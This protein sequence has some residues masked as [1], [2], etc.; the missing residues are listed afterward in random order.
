MKYSWG[1]SSPTRYSELGLCHYHSLK[2][3]E[4]PWSEMSDSKSELSFSECPYSE[5]AL[6]F[7]RFTR[8]PVKT[9]R[10]SI[11]VSPG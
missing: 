6:P 4:N 5:Q 10:A 1:E 2:E 3:S 9:F 8:A 11:S 7:S